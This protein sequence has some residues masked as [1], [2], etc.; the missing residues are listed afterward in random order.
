MKRPLQLP[1]QDYNEMREM[2]DAEEHVEIDRNAWK[3]DEWKDGEDIGKHL[4]CAQKPRHLDCRLRIP[5]CGHSAGLCTP[6][7]L[8]WHEATADK[9]FTQRQCLPA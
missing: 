6:P 1:L 3:R 9:Y 8:Q 5:A 2:L 4:P 7:V